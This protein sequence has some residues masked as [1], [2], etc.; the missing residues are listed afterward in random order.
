MLAASNS[1]FYTFCEVRAT[2]KLF[3]SHLKIMLS[4]V[5][6]GFSAEMLNAALKIEAIYLSFFK[7]LQGFL[8]FLSTVRGE[9]L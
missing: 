8:T 1:L 7:M 2:D 4:A 3:S 5:L 6:G 9:N